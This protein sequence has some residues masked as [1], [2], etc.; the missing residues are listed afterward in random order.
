MSIS[1]QSAYL[2]VIVYLISRS[3]SISL[4][5]SQ[6]Q[7]HL[8]LI[9]SALKADRASTPVAMLVGGDDDDAQ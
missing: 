9:A 2:T 8:F 1:Q 3:R 6:Y 7:L 5:S 4:Y